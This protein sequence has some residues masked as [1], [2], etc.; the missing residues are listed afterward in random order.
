MT[1]FTVKL[2]APEPRLLAVAASLMRLIRLRPCSGISTILRRPLKRS[3]LR[4]ARAGTSGVSESKRP[5]G[6]PAYLS[7]AQSP[8]SSSASSDLGGLAGRVYEAGGNGAPLES[9]ASRE[10]TWLR[11]TPSPMACSI[12][13]KSIDR[14]PPVLRTV[15]TSHSGA[16]APLR[17]AVTISVSQ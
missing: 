4:S 17:S 13:K 2:A 15:W 16:P 8:S 5:M 3:G 7:A 12:R 9:V 1:S 14:P 6:E 10:S 11:A